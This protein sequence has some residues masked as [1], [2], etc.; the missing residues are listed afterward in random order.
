MSTVKVIEIIGTSK[1][2]FEDA[3][4]QAVEKAGETIRGINGVDVIS[5]KAAVENGKI[6]EYRVVLK[7]AFILE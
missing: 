1:A 7:I 5:Q 4:K 6:S 3:I 2:S